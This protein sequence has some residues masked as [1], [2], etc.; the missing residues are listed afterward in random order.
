MSDKRLKGIF[1][2]AAEL[3]RTMPPDLREAAFNRAVDALM[4]R[5]VA[6]GKRTTRDE[7]AFHQCNGAAQDVIPARETELLT[8]ML[9]GAN[10]AAKAAWHGSE[11]LH[12]VL[13]SEEEDTQASPQS[14]QNEP[15][16]PRRRGRA[17]RDAGPVGALQDVASDLI[18]IG[19]FNTARTLSDV[20]NHVQHQG[21][22]ISTR[23][24]AAMMA[25]MT[26]AGLIFRGVNRMGRSFFRS[27]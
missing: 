27:A 22:R 9:Q 4:D 11:I 19:F 18:A 23:D 15:E 8:L 26:Q 5:G 7:G 16:K 3:A 20:V 10:L 12:R 14:A 13:F 25:A 2:E 1:E 17:K 6:T 24:A 21:I